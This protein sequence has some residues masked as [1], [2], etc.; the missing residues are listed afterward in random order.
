MMRWY[1][2]RVALPLLLLAAVVAVILVLV[3]SPGT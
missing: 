3:F 1:V 2:E